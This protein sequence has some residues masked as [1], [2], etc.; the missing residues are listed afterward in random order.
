[1]RGIDPGSISSN[2]KTEQSRNPPE[3]CIH[4]LSRYG[5]IEEDLQKLL[6]I[7]ENGLYCA[8]NGTLPSFSSHPQDGIM[9]LSI[10]LTEQALMK[11]EERGSLTNR[12]HFSMLGFLPEYA[13]QVHKAD[14]LF[15]CTIFDKRR[16]IIVSEEIMPQ[17]KSRDDKPD[18]WL[19]FKTSLQMMH[20]QSVAANGSNPQDYILNVRGD[21]RIIRP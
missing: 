4:I 15:L 1:L 16:R 3:Q 18:S 11:P 17:P 6:K 5:P 19:E 9:P 14:V 7:P 13:I 12:P 10:M 21:V 8:Y 20:E 2:L